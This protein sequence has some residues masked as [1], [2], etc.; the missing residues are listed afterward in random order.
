M[1]SINLSTTNWLAKH[2]FGRHY[3][4]FQSHN[5]EQETKNVFMNAQLPCV[6]AMPREEN[7]P[8]ANVEKRR[9]NKMPQIT[10]T[11]QFVPRGRRVRDGNAS[12]NAACPCP[13]CM[14]SADRLQ[15]PHMDVEIE[16]HPV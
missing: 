6:D 8:H 1:K 12:Q 11:A 3:C 2:K 4:N 7:D 14:Y 16:G 15:G 10:L 13:L 5:F 9:L